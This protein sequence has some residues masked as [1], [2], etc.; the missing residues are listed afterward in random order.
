MT[1]ETQVQG[2]TS[3]PYDS[4]AQ[5]M[6]SLPGVSQ[7]T[8]FFQGNPMATPV[9]QMIEKATDATLPSENWALNLEVCDLINDSGENGPRDAV[10]AIRKRLQVSVGNRNFT[11]VMYTLTVLETCVKN[12]GR[13]FHVHVA[14]KDFLKDLTNIMNPKHDPPII[15]QDK[16][17]TLIQ[18]WSIAFQGAPELRAAEQTYQDLKARGII[19]PTTDMEAAVP[20]ITPRRSTQ[21]PPATNSRP[22][23]AKTT[24]PSN[25]QQ[26]LPQ[27]HHHPQHPVDRPLT[28]SSHGLPPQPS[29]QQIVEMSGPVAP[30][31]DQMA[32]LRSELDIVNGNIIVMGDMLNEMVPGEEDVADLELL[33]ELNRTCRAMQTRLLELIEKISVE[34]VI[35]ELLHVNDDLNNVFLRFER[36]ERYRTGKT[37]NNAASAEANASPHVSPSRN[38]AERQQPVSPLID[39]SSNAVPAVAA[40]AEEDVA[41]QLASL[42]IVDSTPAPR[43][44]GAQAGGGAG[45]NAT[46]DEFKEMEAW[47]SATGG[48][49]GA[50]SGAVSG[51]VGAVSSSE[52]DDFLASRLGVG[53]DSVAAAGVAVSSADT[54]SGGSSSS[55][56]VIRSIGDVPSIS[57]TS[58]A[59]PRV[60][61][62]P[63]KKNEDQDLLLG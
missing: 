63:T 4:A 10:R 21:P 8:S 57:A 29:V 44:D 36:F 13:R 34:E 9:G 55:P 46:E 62:T 43:P 31:P 54:V 30:T 17:L 26:S 56:A 24:A 1:Q 14:Q 45:F 11:V 39:L 50:G 40:D 3:G 2:S 37:S 48:D 38:N 47:L 52:F 7:V 53:A 49:A 27:H 20:I 6:A 61:R 51:S 22:S 41:R 23:P 19:F 32:K 12:C 5:M 59:V 42:G 58:G 35:E 15:V 60:N 28:T 16:I 25:G 33:Q 18:C